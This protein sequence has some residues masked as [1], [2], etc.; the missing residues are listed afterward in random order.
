[1]TQQKLQIRTFFTEGNEGGVITGRDELPLVRIS[2]IQTN[3][4][5]RE[6]VPTG[7]NS[8]WS[9]LALALAAPVIP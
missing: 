4:D 6:L 5:E 7:R 2:G 1:M 3:P 9:A 8:G